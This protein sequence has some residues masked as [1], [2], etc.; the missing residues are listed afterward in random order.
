[1]TQIVPAGAARNPP[2]CAAQTLLMR[3]GRIDEPRTRCS[4]VGPLK[5]VPSPAAFFSARVTLLLAI[6]TA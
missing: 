5:P 4:A 3:G 1:M 2:D 6:Q